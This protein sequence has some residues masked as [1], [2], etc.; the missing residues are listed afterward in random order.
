MPLNSTVRRNLD[1]LLENSSLQNASSWLLRQCGVTDIR[2]N[3][4]IPSHGP[5]LVI[6][7]HTSALDTWALFAATP[8]DDVYTVAISLFKAFGERIRSRCFFVYL[9]HKPQRYPLDWLRVQC[10][11]LME[12]LSRE[13]ALEKNREAIRQASKTISQGGV[14]T[15]FPT[16]GEIG[17]SDNWKPGVGYLIKQITHPDAKIIF[18]KIDG[19]DRSDLLR[20][21]HPWV[22]RLILSDKQIEVTFSPP[23]PLHSFHKNN[24]SARDVTNE[25][26][27]AYQRHIPT[28]QS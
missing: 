16:G 25:V 8:R 11:T 12:G 1:T 7:N 19:T 24:T 23:L 13:E 21:L 14:V 2:T 22:R 6:S 26:K 20:F 15:I 28:K 10:F 5:V 27:K 18:A 4:S 17:S 3:G 9:S